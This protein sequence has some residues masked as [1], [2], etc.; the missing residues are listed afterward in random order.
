[1][2]NQVQHVD[3]K[4]KGQHVGEIL[5]VLHHSLFGPTGIFGIIVQATEVSPRANLVIFQKHGQQF[6]VNF[7]MSFWVIFVSLWVRKGCVR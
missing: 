2:H 7:F 4:L 6:C 5:S 3:C 1:M